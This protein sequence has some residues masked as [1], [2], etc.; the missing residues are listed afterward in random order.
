MRVSKLVSIILF[1]ASALAART[2]W[3]VNYDEAVNGD[4]SGDRLNPTAIALTLGLNR[5]TATSQSGDLEYFRLTVPSGFRLSAAN[6]IS[7]TSPSVSFI[8]VQSGSTFTEPPGNPNVANLLGYTH[9]GVGNGTVGTDILDNM[10]SVGGGTI[11]FVPPLV[12][13]SYTFWAQETGASATYAIEFVLIDAR[14]PVPRG[15]IALLA[16]ALALIGFV[17]VRRRPA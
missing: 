8:A 2:A 16:A 1:A 14:V 4:L 6:V 11:G 5:V 9:F 3:A 13:G 15:A 7:N 10:G 17:S 12:T